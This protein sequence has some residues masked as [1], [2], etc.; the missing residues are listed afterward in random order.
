MP[1]EAPVVAVLDREH[2]PRPPGLEPVAEMAA[3]RYAASVQELEDALAD[4]DVLLVWDFRSPKLR[5]A[6]PQAR[7]LKWVH[8][9]GVGVEAVL[10]PELVSSRVILT[11]S[12]GVFDQAIAE[13]VLGLILMFAKG[14]PTT[15]DLQR[16]HVWQH[17]ETERLV[18][19]TVL[20]VGAGGI[21]RAIGRLARGV[22]LRVV[23]VARTA[24]ASDPDLGRVVA[25]RDLE[26][27]LTDADYVVIAL[28]LTSETKGMFGAAAFGRMK[29]TARL[30]N[31]ARGPIVDEEALIDALRAKRIA[32][33][34]L[35]VFTDEP[36]PA[37]HPFWDLPGVIVSPHM[38]GDF[39]G[40]A[41]GLSQLFVDNFRRWR[42]GEP[43]LNV[44]DKRRGYVPTPLDPPSAG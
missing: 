2:G 34:A 9:A 28:P 37:D 18:G 1:P 20:V 39:T 36:L 16:R 3:V 25:L 17:R 27:L 23:G 31:V 42:R 38:S 44:V 10:F 12:R 5:T 11:N 8:V 7:R 33:A 29:P 26:A 40:W 30:I 22:G 43:L 6:W 19:Q 41:A 35:D 13:Y 24:R 15:L 32:G 21:G 14:V 4:A